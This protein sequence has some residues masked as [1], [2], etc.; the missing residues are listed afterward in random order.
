[1]RLRR[2]TLRDVR[3][4]ET[5]TVDL[6]D[7]D[8][9]TGVVI[10]AGPN[11]AG[12]STLGDALHVLLDYKA[13]SRAGDVT[14]LKPSDRD[15]GPEVEAELQIGEHRVVYRKRWLRRPVTELS[16]LAPRR[17]ALTGDEAHERVQELLA[18]QVDVGLWTSLRLRQGDGLEQPAVG[19]AAGLAAAL[20]RRTEA[21]AIGDG[22]LAVLAAVR[23]ERARHLTPTGR[24]T[25]ELR[26]AEQAEA[27]ARE[28]LAAVEGRLADLRADVDAAD[29]LAA[30]LP[31]LETQLEAADARAAELAEQLAA[32]ER[33]AGVV[34]DR[35]RD[36]DAAQTG[37]T[38]LEERAERRADLVADLAAAESAA[39][40]LRVERGTADEAL[41]AAAGRL[42]AAERAVAEAR[43]R[44]RSARSARERAQDDLDHLQQDAELTAL[45]D[46]IAR[47]DDARERLRAALAEVDASPVDR[48]GLDRLR[49]AAQEADRTRIVLDAACPELRFTADRDVVVGEG[50]GSVQL[51]SGDT[52]EWTVRGALRL[53]LGTVGEVEVTAGTGTE[54]AAAAAR[55]AATALADAL[56]AA[57]V[58]DLDAAEQ[59]HRRREEAERSAAEARRDRDAALAGA[60]LDDLREGAERLAATLAARR[61][62]RREDPSPPADLDAARAALAEAR[63]AADSAEEALADATADLERARAAQ[64]SCS[65]AVIRLRTRGEDLDRRVAA[66][67]DA[68][69]EAREATADEKL[70]R[71]LADA[72]ERCAAAEAALAAAVAELD[73]AEP[74][75]V[76]TLARNA[77]AVAEDARGTRDVERARLRDLR[78]AVAARGGEG[79]HEQRDEAAA[80]HAAAAQRLASLRRRAAAADLLV[81][82]LERHRSAAQERY[83]A[84]LRAQLLTYGRILHGADFDVEL[85]EDLRVVRR[86]V[87]GLTLDVSQLSVGAQEQL[88]LLSRLACATLL[89]DSG[90]LL[91]LDDALGHTDPERLEAIGAVLGLAGEHCQVLVLTCY[92]ERYRHVGGAR[93]LVLR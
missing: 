3:G 24:S 44:H 6:V 52:H 11:E 75:T 9:T 14:G 32:V 5:R 15:V 22:E 30:A 78:V 57:G 83:A 2:L 50:G 71:E 86:T 31:G 79:L 65:D 7:G 74:E 49:R 17:P 59:A 89:A 51:R 64:R 66:L 27:E 46:R 62:D 10:V 21:S 58:A 26:A 81:T 53:Q 42:D 56:D 69:A 54:D 29:R 48:D 33:L 38:L 68:V 92:P 76:R 60:A 25:G 91:L 47:A 82:T 20:E 55:A 43:E 37:R 19:A 93:R 41:A 40:A 16:W 13:S 63:T 61:A 80:V 12:K 85:D 8:D 70:D 36:L 77:A 84:P 35:R 23:E 90:G 1:M 39:E 73:A 18:E 87:G 88:A 72:R 45:R 34:E 67:R 28:A 4:I